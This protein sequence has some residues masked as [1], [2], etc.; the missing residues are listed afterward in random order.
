[1]KDKVAA[2]LPQIAS[3]AIPL[4]EAEALAQQVR[5]GIN[6][7]PEHAKEWGPLLG[8]I[9]QAIRQRPKPIDLHWVAAGGGHLAIGHKP[10]SK[11]PCSSLKAQGATAVLTLL[12]QNEGAEAIGSQVQHQQ[13]EWIW[14]PFSA[15]HPHQGE[16]L[17]QVAGLY[18]LLQQRLQAGGKVYIHCSAGIHRTGMITV[19]LLRFLGYDSP[20][21]INLLT[22]L[23]PVTAQQVGADRLLWADQFGATPS[24]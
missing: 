12:H 22:H 10:G 4:T 9:S 14:F 16:A 3:G 5:N 24:H 15:S 13:L 8:Q 18:S 1:M 7:H 20:T 19:G 23:R 11:V 6:Q 17:L 2:L 21:S